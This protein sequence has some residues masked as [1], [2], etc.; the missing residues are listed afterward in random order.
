MTENTKIFSGVAVAIL[1]IIIGGTYYLSSREKIAELTQSPDKE[2]PGAVLS[3]DAV[4][5][6]AKHS[7]RNGKHIVAG[8][9]EVPTPCH[10][11][12]VETVIRESSPEQVTLVFNTKSDADVCAQVISSRRFKMEFNAEQ[13]AS[14]G[15]TFNG[16]PA[17]LNLIEAGPNE[18]LE[19]FDIYLKG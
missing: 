3:E 12:S 2:L 6:N 16:K 10:S 1:L 7:F 18:D 5:I 14:I 11:L 8:E 13:N 17:I 15:A 4:R 9:V 19:N